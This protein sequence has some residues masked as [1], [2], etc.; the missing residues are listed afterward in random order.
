MLIAIALV[1]PLVCQGQRADKRLIL[2]AAFGWAVLAQ[3]PVLHF[4]NIQLP[5]GAAIMAILVWALTTK[6]PTPPDDSTSYNEIRTHLPKNS[7]EANAFLA[8][9]IAAVLAIVPVGYFIYATITH[10]P[11]DLQQQGPILLFVSAGAL[12]QLVGWILAGLIFAGLSTRLFGGVGPGRAL[13]LSSTWFV[14]AFAVHIIDGWTRGT[15]GG[16]A[17][18]FPGFELLLFL[19]VFSIIWDACTARQDSWKATF[20][21]LK[22]AYNIQETRVAL[23]YVLSALVALIILG[24]QIVN[25]SGIQAVRSVLEVIP[26]LK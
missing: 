3:L 15:G 1:I 4:A 23:Y 22:K 20:D 7:P 17:W 25:G 12:S 16:R 26:P 5:V 11:H 14:A 19:L 10:L 9:N 8:C 24:E 21:K 13:V 6:R 2:A 18:S